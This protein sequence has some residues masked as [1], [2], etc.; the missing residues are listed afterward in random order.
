MHS[1]R[2]ALVGGFQI[3]EVIAANAFK[4]RTLEALKLRERFGA[5]VLTIKRK[6]KEKGDEVSYM[7]P[8]ASTV[9]EEEDVLIVFGSQ[10]DLSRF[11]HD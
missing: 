11:P 4:G 5:T 6:A 7:I 1:K 9:I 2:L 8:T 10:K 3:L